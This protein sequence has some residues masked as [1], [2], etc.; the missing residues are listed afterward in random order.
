MLGNVNSLGEPSKD[1]EKGKSGKLA[2]AVDDEFEMKF[3]DEEQDKQEKEE[4]K[5]NSN[6]TGLNF[7]TYN[8]STVSLKNASGTMLSREITSMSTQ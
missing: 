6:P 8:G 7:T 1:E 2:L 5:V 4:E 3:S